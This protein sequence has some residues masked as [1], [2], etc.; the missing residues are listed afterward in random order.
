[1]GKILPEGGDVQL[2]SWQKPTKQLTCLVGNFVVLCAP[3]MTEKGFVLLLAI[4]G[5]TACGRSQV[6]ALQGEAGS[7]SSK[8]MNLDGQSE[9][10]SAAITD[11]SLGPLSDYDLKI[12]TVLV[13]SGLP[14]LDEAGPEKSFSTFRHSNAGNR[15]AKIDDKSRV[16]YSP[17]SNLVF[18]A[19]QQLPPSN[20][21]LS[22][23]SLKLRL[24]GVRMFVEEGV[25]PESGQSIC[26]LDG[27]VCIGETPQM[28]KDRGSGGNSKFW[29]GAT[30][31]RS[32]FLKISEWKEVAKADGGS[33]YS[34]DSGEIE[35]DLLQSL[36]LN[37]KTA[38]EFIFAHSDTYSA[39]ESGYRK[40]RFSMGDRILADGGELILELDVNSVLV[41]KDYEKRL[42]APAHGASDM[43]NYESKRKKAI[44]KKGEKSLQGEFLWIL[45]QEEIES[46]RVS[47]L[48]AKLTPK[49][50]QIEEIRLVSLGGEKPSED[51]AGIA[52]SEL[53]KAGWSENVIHQVTKIE[54]GAGPL[55]GVLVKFVAA[56]E[57]NPA[58]RKKLLDEILKEEV[59][60]NEVSN[61]NNDL[62]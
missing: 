49:R 28:S 8:I 38:I 32:D 47:E 2:T 20:S 18:R 27:K 42:P 16:S 21:I 59:K 29:V 60:T 40:F 43:I 5:L 3:M 13:E 54:G 9:Q 56:I 52:K 37:E 30:V 24:N 58:E 33:I 57:K 22:V 53:L 17:H 34:N 19:I 51:L 1:M 41:P 12:D 25:K 61:E 23:K 50:D 15:K 62:L 4:I 10:E 31:H 48:N 46:G 44:L 55:V 14:F 11:G 45:N 36:S 35:V 6:T 39:I 7:G 26:I